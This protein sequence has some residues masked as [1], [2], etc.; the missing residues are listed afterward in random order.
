MAIKVEP[1]VWYSADEVA[2][3]MA[4]SK[5]TLDLERSKGGGAPYSKI[6]RRVYYRGSDLLAHIDSKRRRST[7][8]R[9]ETLK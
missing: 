6:G 2:E 3:A 8:D 4:I 5:K 1:D 7:A 9:P